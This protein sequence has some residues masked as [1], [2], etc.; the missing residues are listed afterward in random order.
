MVTLYS[1][2]AL[3][4]S[5]LTSLMCF[6]IFNF[7][8]SLFDFKIAYYLDLI[9]FSLLA[10]LFLRIISRWIP[11]FKLWKLNGFSITK[12]GWKK[13]FTYEAVLWVFKFTI[14]V[15]MSLYF[16]IGKLF[17]FALVCY[18][19]ESFLYLFLLRK[20]FKLCISDQAITLT[21]HSLLVIN[22][23]R[24]DSITKRHNTLQFK[25][26]NKAVKIVDLEL[27]NE[28]DKTTFEQKVKKIAYNNNAYFS[29]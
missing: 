13:S 17:C 29:S 2:L 28:L 16:E 21:N 19:I 3:A 8:I 12:L 20:G 9:S 5:I 26:K 23:D 18:I 11:V 14:V 6:L 10:I 25:L 4:I 24:V 1:R 15:F 7:N 22:W 27:L